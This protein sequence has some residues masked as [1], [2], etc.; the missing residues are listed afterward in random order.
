[1]HAFI[2][3]MSESKYL[4]CFYSS[5]LA[6]LENRSCLRDKSLKDIQFHYV[7]IIK[8]IYVDNKHTYVQ[9]SLATVLH[10]LT[11]GNTLSMLFD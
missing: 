3:S 9:C 2:Y 8:Y 7:F 5:K 6:A 11:S 1:M 10:S 4:H